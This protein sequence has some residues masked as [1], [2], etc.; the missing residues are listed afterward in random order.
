MMASFAN[1]ESQPRR[2]QR[3]GSAP[4]GGRGRAR[5]SRSPSPAVSG[6]S[7]GGDA[8]Q[9][10]EELDNG[11]TVWIGHLPQSCAA[12]AAVVKDALSSFGSVASV[13]VREKPGA[14]KSW[15][16][17]TFYDGGAARAAVHASHVPVPDEQGKLVRCSV[18]HAD[19]QHQLEKS[20]TGWL[21]TVA[22]QH[23]RKVQEAAA[24]SAHG[25]SFGSDF[26]FA[27]KGHPQ[28]Q[29]NPTRARPLLRAPST[30]TQKGFVALETELR[31]VW[32]SGELAQRALLDAH[33]AGRR[34]GAE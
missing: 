14:R 30:N 13:T 12:D 26:Q 27:S 28:Y 4:A 6:G 16:L 10:V 15:A 20:S 32:R 25:V 19:V 2:Q 33:A 21:G 7:G 34:P 8:S 17:A 31:S 1:G 9:P 18:Q 29:Q 22:R 11:H 24:A 23:S 5:A 3:G